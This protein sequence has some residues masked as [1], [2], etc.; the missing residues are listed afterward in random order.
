[1]TP[2]EQVTEH[3]RQLEPVLAASVEAIRQ[4]ILRTDASIGEQIKWNNPCFYY[5]GEMKPFTPKA[6]KRE[7]AVFNLFKGRLMLVF[8]SGATVNDTSGLL[9]GAYTDGRRLAVFKD[10]DDIQAKAADLQDVIIKWLQ[11]VEK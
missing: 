5:T 8:P 6:Y 3:I 11:L 1:M 10:M 2:S 7:I 4:I 9:E